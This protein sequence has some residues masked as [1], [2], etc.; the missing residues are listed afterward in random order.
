MNKQRKKRYWRLREIRKERDY[1][2]GSLQYANR[3]YT[4]RSV[5]LL[6][7]IGLV[8]VQI[9]TNQFIKKHKINI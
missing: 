3:P 6:F 8:R 9:T 2:S 4:F 7:G 1:Q 5:R